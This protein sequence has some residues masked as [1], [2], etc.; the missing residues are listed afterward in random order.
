M[1]G[2]GPGTLT[3][4]IGGGNGSK[5]RTPGSGSERL[6]IVHC[7]LPVTQRHLHHAREPDLL[8]VR[9]SMPIALMHNYIFPVPLHWVH[10]LGLQRLPTEWDNFCG[11]VPNSRARFCSV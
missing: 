7:S 10:Q 3:A 9:A 1:P 5:L 11:A 4:K 2:D 8:A 6:Q